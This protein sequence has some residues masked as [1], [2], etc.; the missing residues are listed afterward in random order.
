MTYGQ[1]TISSLASLCLG[2]TAFALNAS[3]GPNCTVQYSQTSCAACADCE[4]VNDGWRCGSE[5]AV[6]QCH[7]TQQAVCGIGGTW[8]D[9]EFKADCEVVAT[10]PWRQYSSITL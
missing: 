1:K 2:A 8:N 7:G 3:T 5:R 9:P 6:A 4:R 10:V